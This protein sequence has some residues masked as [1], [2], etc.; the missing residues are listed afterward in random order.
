MKRL[1]SE[2]NFKIHFIASILLCTIIEIV[3]RKY[4]TG[5]MRDSNYTFLD[6]TGVNNSLYFERSDHI[7]NYKILL[8]TNM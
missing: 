7:K 4:F 5:N 6:G 1:V 3:S 2:Y 8:G